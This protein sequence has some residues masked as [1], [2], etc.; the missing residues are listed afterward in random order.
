MAAMMREE[1]RDFIIIIE[2]LSSNLAKDSK[3][4]LNMV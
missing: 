3:K 4:Y 1:L 2:D